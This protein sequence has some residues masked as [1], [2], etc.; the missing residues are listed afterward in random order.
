MMSG[1]RQGMGNRLLVMP[2]LC[3]IAVTGGATVTARSSLR[4]LAEDVEI[5]SCPR[6]DM[7]FSM[8][9]T[10]PFGERVQH[11]D[12]QERGNGF[13]LMLSSRMRLI[14]VAKRRDWCFTRTVVGSFLAT[15]CSADP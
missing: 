3:L 2:I 11:V 13:P 1:R 10:T 12:M 8:V 14:I 7:M 9:Q 4:G 6:C 15:L 5:E